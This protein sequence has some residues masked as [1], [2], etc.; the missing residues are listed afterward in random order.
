[1]ERYYF[2]IID[3][4]DHLDKEGSEWPDLAAVR[5]EAIRLSGEI[6]KE[7]PERF[8]HAEKWRMT[9]SDRHRT[10]MFTLQFYAEDSATN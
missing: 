9:V 3:G 2:D 6:L 4:N 5:I 7:M 10:P 8:W 1:M